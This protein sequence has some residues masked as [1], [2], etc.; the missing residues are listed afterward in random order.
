M[1]VQIISDQ[2]KKKH[3]RGESHIRTVKTEKNKEGLEARKSLL[4]EKVN[5][6]CS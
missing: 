6:F 5:L 3:E 2:H 4:K 1:V